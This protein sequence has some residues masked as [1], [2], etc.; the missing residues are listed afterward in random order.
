M[1]LC[2]YC[3]KDMLEVDGCINVPHEFKDGKKLNPIKFGDE[4]E[5]WGSKDNDARCH[6]CNCK[7]GKYHHPNCDVERCPKCKG[8]AI[9]CTCHE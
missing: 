3:G 4:K 2:K 8:Q 6:D 9:S 5:D 1:V 7:V